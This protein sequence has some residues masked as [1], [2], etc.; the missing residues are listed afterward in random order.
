MKEAKRPD[1]K[2]IRYPMLPMGNLKDYEIKS[3]WAYLQTVP[4]I[5]NKVDRTEHM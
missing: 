3:L 2:P 5:H 1:G 4:Q